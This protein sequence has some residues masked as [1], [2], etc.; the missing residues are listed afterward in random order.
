ME[1]QNDRLPGEDV[2]CAGTVERFT[3]RNQESGFA[4]VRLRPD[5]PGPV[6]SAV[7]QL[8]QFAEGQRL[9]LTGRLVLHPRF[10]RQIDVA[11]V[12]AELPRSAEGVV[13]YLSS[14][15]VKGV[16][17][18]IAQR[19]VDHFG[20]EVLDI[21]DREPERL[22]EVK[23]FG[24]KRAAE[25]AEALRGQRDVQEVMVFLRTHGLGAALATRICKRYGKGA[26]SLIT[27]DPYRLA[28]EVVGVGFKTA[29]Q[30]ARR[31]GI[32]ADA[33]TR[34]RAGTVFTLAEGARAGH[35]FLDL[36]DLVQTTAALLDADA[37]RIEA[38]LPNLSSEGRI[39]CEAPA[40]G[41]ADQPPRV[42]PRTLHT[43][44]TG[45]A[46]VL[47]SILEGGF[48]QVPLAPE[49]E[50]EQFATT[51]GVHLPPAQ[52][53][54]LVR[55][56]TAPVSV[57]TGGP[58][59]GKT[60]I[61]RALVTILRAHDLRVR[62]CAPTGRAAKRL[63]ESTGHVAT[64]I[65]RLLEFQ[66]GI[67]RFGRNAQT[68][69]EGHLLVVDETSMLDV[70]LAYSLLRAIP[71]GMRLV[72]VGDADQLP[73]V[74]P[75]NFLRDLIESGVVPVT[76][77]TEVFRQ[78]RDSHI[79]TAAHEILHGRVPTSGGEGSDFFIVETRD[80]THTRAVVR[81]LVS[82]RIPTAF[83]FDPRSEIQVLAPMYRGEAGADAL[84]VE[85]RETL[86]P[87]REQVTRGTHTFRVGD[88]V[89]QVKNDH[90]REV[91]NGDAGLVTGLDPTTSR[92]SVRFGERVL[93][94][95]LGDLD[96]LVPGFAISVHRAQGSEYPAVVLPMSTEHFLMLKRNLLY[97]AVTR[98]R[99]LVVVVGSPRAL[100]MAVDNVGSDRRNSGLAARLR[101]R[102]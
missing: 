53:M 26:A 3:F 45:C 64:T 8:A 28:D 20:P 73:A 93:E 13:A 23:G 36:P 97:T 70:Q 40:D 72:V 7:G 38:E 30:V 49:Q 57:I 60:T 29:D 79:V 81:E 14:G 96:Q 85:L 47:R 2:T 46:E 11:T 55:A 89:L 43:A 61:V 63:E 90:D 16:G 65:H 74:G 19:L 66:A 92:L 54:A 32:A 31:M 6:F 17:P 56:L 101:A 84:N 68:P 37:T 12:E 102:A 33:P 95:P 24:R 21:A 71:P 22:R 100:A 83:G 76:A 52:R 34:L 91:Y 99:R 59:V 44:E 42:Y 27:A 82:N 5:A 86:N 69:L 98:G 75:G 35:C 87:G 39:V 77:L 25:L 58:G 62:L 51:S 41:D 4:V 88:K 78:Q 67:Y 1:T 15:L 9:R 80:A 94:Y 10:G 50:V 48:P 18:A